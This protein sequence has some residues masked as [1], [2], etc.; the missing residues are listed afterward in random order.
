M[1]AQRRDGSLFR[2]SQRRGPEIRC[3]GITRPP[4]TNGFAG[5]GASRCALSESLDR[6]LPEART[7]AP[8]TVG[9]QSGQP[10]PHEA[11]MTLFDEYNQC[12]PK[13]A[14]RAMRELRKR[15]LMFCGHF[16]TDNA[17]DVLAG[18]DEAISDGKLYEWMRDHLGVVTDERV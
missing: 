16:G 17:V 7:A 18:M 8:R 4:A 10:A 2:Q 1:D 6:G 13:E 3:T 11:Q 12:Q 5:G 9:T 15:G 14:Q